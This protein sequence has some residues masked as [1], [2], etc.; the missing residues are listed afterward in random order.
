MSQKQRQDLII[1]MLNEQKTVN[2]N[3]LSKHFNV[4]VITI[5]RDIDTLVDQGI[6]KKVYGGA[7][8]VKERSQENGT[9]HPYF[10][11]RLMKNHK[12]KALIGSTAAKYI[13]DGDT[14]ILDIGTT[15]LEIAKHIKER[16]DI[17]VL[18]N[19][20]AI[21]NEL[22]DSDLEVHA[23]GGKLRSKEMSL[24]GSQAYTAL[25]EFC[26]TKAFISAGAIS[27]ANGLTDFNRDS[28]E[29][30][31]AIMRR[32]DHVYLVADSTKFGKSTFS[33]LGGLDCIDT[34]ITDSGIPEEYLRKF[35]SIGVEVII[36]DKI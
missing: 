20:L 4:S 19:S 1:S 7:T 9:H 25:S 17:T 14:I 2:I 6:A 24:V 32:A 27:L 30:C 16:N 29:L 12:E 31:A 13:H 3:D 33:V 22:L 11:N 5:R 10:Y 21:L 36:A 34:L 35:E 8:L 15:C 26:A 18:T 23:L 28:A